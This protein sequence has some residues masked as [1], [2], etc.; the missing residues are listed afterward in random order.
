MNRFV[1]Q[2]DFN[3]L[4][5]NRWLHLHVVRGP[6]T[7]GGYVYTLCGPPGTKLM[8]AIGGY[9]YTLCVAPWDHI[10]LRLNIFYKPT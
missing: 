1:L 7:I 5:I 3:V 8:Y 9:V 6:P 2:V 4:N 10:D